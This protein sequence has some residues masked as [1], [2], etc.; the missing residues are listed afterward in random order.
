MAL[1]ANNR[2]Q[3]LISHLTNSLNINN[4][5]SNNNNN[6]NNNINNLNFKNNCNNYE[7]KSGNGN[8]IET[9]EKERNNCSFDIRELTYFLDGNEENTQ[10]KELILS[11][12]EMEDVFL[13]SYEDL[14][15]EQSRETT[16]RK[17][18]RVVERR[19]AMM[20]GQGEKNIESKRKNAAPK[21][22]NFSDNL[23]QLFYDSVGLFDT[24][25]ATRLAVHF[26]LFGATVL[27]QG[28]DEQRAQY[29]ESIDRVQI[30]GCFCMTELGHGSY[31]KGIETTA[32]FDLNTDEFI[33]NSPTLTST[34]WWI[35]ALAETA[36]H[37]V[38]YAR[39]ILKGNDYGPHVFIVQLRNVNNGEILD[40]RIIGDC[41]TKMGRNGLDNGW[42]QFRNVR[43]PRQN[44]LMRWATVS[45]NGEYIK[46]P[47]Q[48][49]SYASLLAGRVNMVQTSSDVVK[50]AI[51]IAIRYASVRRQFHSS[52]TENQSNLI[53]TN[54]SNQLETPLIDYQTH[55]FRLLPLLSGVFAFH[56]T[57][58]QIQKLYD[59][60]L[61][62]IESEN[63]DRLADVH[64][65]SA[66][67]KAIATWWANSAIEQCRQC[68]GG[69][70]YSAYS[71]FPS[72]L[73]D[74]GPMVTWE[75][76]N[77]VLI[78]QTARALIN[79][80]RN[81]NLNNSN[82]SNNS[83][84]NSNLENNLNSDSTT[85]FGFREVPIND[86]VNLVG[87][88]FKKVANKYD[89]MNDAMSIGIHRLW[90]DRFVSTLAPLPGINHLDVAGGT[91]DIAFRII[92][93]IRNSPNYFPYSEID[94]K[95]NKN[96]CLTKHS[97]ITIC[98]INPEMLRVGKSRANEKGYHFADPEINWLVG[99][100]ENLAIPSDSIDSYTI[101]FGIR[102][103]TNI[104]AVLSEAHRVL[105]KGGRFLCLE[106]CP[107][108][109]HPLLT[110]VYDV[111]SFNF[112]PILGQIITQDKDS[113]TY[114]VESIRKFP[115][116]RDFANLI[117][118]AG[119]KYANY[120][121]LTFGVC[122]IHSGW[123][124]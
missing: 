77:T 41:G 40:G 27:G 19:R 52:D 94:S 121:L 78:L 55:Q 111:Y 56:F 5:D 120:E 25:L 35:G 109:V 117:E 110:N 102:N 67:L 99:D 81:S 14:S 97:K 116:A 23:A 29:F 82:N 83:N 91:G 1:N 3:T 85:H 45:T 119:F 18:L 65:T 76:D 46:P 73:A 93:T 33:I 75:G 113:Y 4:N 88:V 20:D 9:I 28:T 106:F 124:I 50:K 2:I 12:L 95:E 32:T 63:L 8:C 123:K 59:K 92:D 54:L 104:E 61:N 74:F 43:I 37:A 39:L 11:T 34:K 7:N 89:V 53:I 80:V 64:S 108:L 68:C 79:A 107:E 101:S 13:E 90:K 100:A 71:G 84:L 122:A 70:G 26:G 112:I 51:T 98:D 6:N 38:V 16:M 115:K 17:L 69:H 96:N 66:G 10:F 24:S 47:K 15:R 21:Q 62:E 31:V 58:A 114:L 72:M 44:M 86:K 118:K 87:E 57:G 105:K 49:L 42:A 36:T 103:C 30:F 22:T 48:Q 60:L